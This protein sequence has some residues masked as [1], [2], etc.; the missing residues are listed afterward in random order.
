MDWQQ[1]K[2]PGCIKN[3][4]GQRKELR[5]ALVWRR[6]PAH[7]RS[8]QWR[9]HASLHGPCQHFDAWTRSAP[10]HTFFQEVGAKRMYWIYNFLLYSLISF[11]SVDGEQTDGTGKQQLCPFW[12]RPSF[13]DTVTSSYKVEKK[14]AAV[15]SWMDYWLY[16]LGIDLWLLTDLCSRS[17]RTKHKTG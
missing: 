13:I 9:P 16:W 8:K 10:S 12:P 1:H 7:R 11:L 2:S 14:R 17:S 6:V 3:T 5:F 15:M 4:S